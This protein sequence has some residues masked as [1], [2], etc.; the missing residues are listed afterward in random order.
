MNGDTAPTN[1]TPVA[2]PVSTVLPE[3]YDFVH[4][5]KKFTKTITEIV[6]KLNFT[7]YL[8]ILCL[9]ARNATAVADLCAPKTHR[10]LLYVCSYRDMSLELCEIIHGHIPRTK[11]NRENG[12]A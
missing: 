9:K 12:S 7:L 2:S 3:H 10:L 11:C 5:L 1:C 8:C 6:I 4:F